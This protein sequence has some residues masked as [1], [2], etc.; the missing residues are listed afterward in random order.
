MTIHDIGWRADSR[1]WFCVPGIC[2][3]GKTAKDCPEPKRDITTS[4]V[5]ADED[6]QPHPYS[7]RC[8]ACWSVNASEMEAQ[9]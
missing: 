7:C 6:G 5:L 1:G 2:S 3:C 8:D 4:Q 9:R